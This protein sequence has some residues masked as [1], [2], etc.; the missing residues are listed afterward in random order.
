MRAF[1]LL[2]VCALFFV[3]SSEAMAKKVVIQT[4]RMPDGSLIERKI[5]YESWLANKR[6][7]RSESL[8]AR[9]QRGGSYAQ[10]IAQQRANYMAATGMSGHP[11]LSAGSWIAAGGR[12][13]GVGW[14]S[15]PNAPHHAIPTCTTSGTPIADAV[16]RGPGGSYRVRIW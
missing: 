11:P 2:L 12:F 7:A 8:E 16:A 6:V 13:E 9:V 5:P 10:Q 15:S 3:A 14:H 1:R 4:V